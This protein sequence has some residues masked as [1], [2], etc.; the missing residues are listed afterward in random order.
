M[1]KGVMMITQVEELNEIRHKYPKAWKYIMEQSDEKKREGFLEAM[2]PT[3]PRFDDND[4][5]IGE[6]Y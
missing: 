4:E 3:L 2:T 1:K 6:G 5:M